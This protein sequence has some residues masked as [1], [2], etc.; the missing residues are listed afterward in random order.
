MSISNSYFP[1]NHIY[2]Y[3]VTLVTGSS[4]SSKT[5]VFAVNLSYILYTSTVY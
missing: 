3:S 4:R 1:V 2:S 5:F